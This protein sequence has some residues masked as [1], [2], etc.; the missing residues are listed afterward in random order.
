MS[1]DL[2]SAEWAEQLLQPRRMEL[3][4]QTA[5]LGYVREQAFLEGVTAHLRDT[6]WKCPFCHDGT[7]NLPEHL[8][9]CEQVPEHLREELPK[10]EP[11]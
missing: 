8:I 6:Y 3:D 9:T 2:T 7:A 10:V 5:V 1:R 11:R 4:H